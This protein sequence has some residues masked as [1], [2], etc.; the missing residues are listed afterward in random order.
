[1]RKERVELAINI[2][3]AGCVTECWVFNRLAI[4]RTSKYYE[5][6][7]ASHYP[8]YADSDLNFFFGETSSLL[9]SYHDLILDRKQIH[10]FTLNQDSI[11]EKAKEMLADGYYL[12]MATKIPIEI[13]FYHEVLLYGFDDVNECFLTVDIQDRLFRPT[14]YSY[15]YVRNTF[16]EVLHHYRENECMGMGNAIYY[17]FP[18]TAMRINKNYTP[19]NCP[20]EAYLKLDDEWHGVCHRKS[21]LQDLERQNNFERI[22]RGLSCL[23]ALKKLLKREIAGEPF[24]ESFRGV[25]YAVKKISEHHN[26]MLISMKYLKNKWGTVMNEMA[27][28]CICRYENCVIKSKRWMNIVLKYEQTKDIELLNKIV[29]EIPTTYEEEYDILDIFLHKSINWIEFN[30]KYI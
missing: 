6:W 12:I 9:P 15:S 2:E 19:E 16:S 17:Q 27:D 14:V 25:S 7:I 5:D 4:V 10:L 24:P 18:I 30:E 8:L 3:E 20:F 13:E 21:G 11:V 26:F 28:A 29:L 23:Y 1:M 22:Y